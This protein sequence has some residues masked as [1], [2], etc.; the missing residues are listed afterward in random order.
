MKAHKDDFKRGARR[1]I[2]SP[3]VLKELHFS[4]KSYMNHCKLGPFLP[5]QKILSS[6]QRRHGFLLPC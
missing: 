2:Y 5:I 3:C 4:I 6:F 1:Q